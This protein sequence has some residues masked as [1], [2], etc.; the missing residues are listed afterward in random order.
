MCSKDP[1]KALTWRVRN[2]YANE[3]LVNWDVYGSAIT[4]SFVAAPASDTYFDTPLVEN[5]ANTV[6]IY[7][8][9]RLEDTKASGFTKCA[10]PS[11]TPT[12]TAS[13]TAT[14]TLTPTSPPDSTATPVPTKTPE[15]TAT[16]QP[17]STPTPSSYR[18]GGEVKSAANGRALTSTE[19]TRLASLKP[20]INAVCDGKLISTNVNNNAKWS[21]VLPDAYCRVSIVEGNNTARLDVVSKPVAYL[22]YSNELS[23]IGDREG[24]L[25]FA[26]RIVTSTVAGN[27]GSGGVKPISTPKPTATPKSK[28]KSKSSQRKQEGRQ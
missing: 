28:K 27:S 18:V 25:N 14:A 8:E 11:P 12:A 24:G 3:I 17:T 20:K 9:G 21:M 7:V 10:Q 16:P 5:S 19:K 26:V 2:P 22:A 15:A 13:P 4:G 1:S 6:R 23:A